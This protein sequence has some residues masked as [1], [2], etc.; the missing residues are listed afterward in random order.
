[1]THSDSDTFLV[2]L[3]ECMTILLAQLP[4]ARVRCDKWYFLVFKTG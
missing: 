2:L 3:F 1:M 4:T